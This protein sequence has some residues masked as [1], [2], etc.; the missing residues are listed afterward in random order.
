VESYDL[1]N[2]KLRTIYL[3]EDKAVN[4]FNYISHQSNGGEYIRLLWLLILHALQ[5]LLWL[6]EVKGVSLPLSSSLHRNPLSERDVSVGFIY[7]YFCHP[8]FGSHFRD[9]VYLLDIFW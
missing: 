1:L 4:K 7:L 8:P 5:F 2:I 6:G 3:W 9:N